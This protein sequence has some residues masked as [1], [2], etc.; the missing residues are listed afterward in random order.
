MVST[1]VGDQKAKD[2]SEDQLQYQMM[3]SSQVMPYEEDQVRT[4][5]E[6]ARRKLDLPIAPVFSCFAFLWGK[7]GVLVC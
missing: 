1:F 2:S 5:P 7:K 4:K 6:T 3:I